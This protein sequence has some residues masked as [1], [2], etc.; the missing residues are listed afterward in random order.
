M[1]IYITF[2]GRKSTA[3]AQQQGEKLWQVCT[4]QTGDGF[5]VFLAAAVR[6][7]NSCEQGAEILTSNWDISLL[8]YS[9]EQNEA[10]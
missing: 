3:T 1:N 9:S 5:I 8:F 6:T 10:P 2:S 4:R 7:Q